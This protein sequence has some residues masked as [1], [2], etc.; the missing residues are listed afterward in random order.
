MRK[1]PI[2]IQSFEK[3]REGNFAYVDKTKYVYDLAHGSG[4]YFLGRPRRFGKSLLLS[5]LNAYFLGQKAL[6]N[7]LAIEKLEDDWTQYPVFHIDLNVTSYCDLT[8]LDRGLDANLMRLEKQW[9]ENPKETSPSMRFYG[10]IQRAYEQ[11]GKKVVV[12]IDEYDKPLLGSLED[13]TANSAMRTRLKGFY[14]VL[15]SSDQWLRFVLLTGVTKFSQVS[16]FSDLNQLQDISLYEAYAGICGITHTELLDN[17]KL[18]LQELAKQNELTYDETIAEMEKRYNGYHFSENSLSVFNPFSALNTFASGKFSYYWFKTGTPTF[19][20]HLLKKSEFNILEF[21]QG[22]KVSVQL[23][24]D[25]RIG[26]DNPV[27]ILYQ[28]G[29][30]TIK[31]YEKRTERYILGFPNEEVEYGFLSQLLPYYINHKGGGNDFDAADFV[32]DLYDNNIEN[33]MVRLRA[34]F[35]SISY[36]L[37]EQTD[38]ASED[39]G[40]N[41]RHYQVIFYLLFTLMGQFTQAEVRSAKGRADVVVI[42]PESVYVFEFKLLRD[43]SIGYTA[44]DALK[45]IDDKGY[46]IPYTASGKK[47]F[48]IG[49]QF[50]ATERNIS[51]WEFTQS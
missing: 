35:A 16:V 40:F 4:T 19:L 38:G 41:E 29:Y 1:M 51:D 23:I 18:E 21:Q 50:D 15:K 44:A 47:L 14:G 27:P 49:V 5:T 24:D 33:F 6:F 43:N 48:K 31:D 45:Q 20:F 9:G 3:L 46:M 28:S 42:I 11:T 13:E 25:Y 34:F 17:F 22:I 37:K 36:E 30:L 12:L 8:D 32:D 2:G 26:S 39:D 10:L 7:G